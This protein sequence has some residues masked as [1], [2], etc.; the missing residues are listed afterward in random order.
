M[1]G[2]N[3]GARPIYIRNRPSSEQHPGE[4]EIGSSILPLGFIEE[5][6][7]RLTVSLSQNHLHVPCTPT[8]SGMRDRRFPMSRANSSLA[9][10][11]RVVKKQA[12]AAIGPRR[13]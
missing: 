5:E 13:S 6:G 7:A 2:P 12:M 11:S 1:R 10:R 8:C 4:A 3:L 9:N